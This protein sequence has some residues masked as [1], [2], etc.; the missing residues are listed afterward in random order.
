[1]V[2]GELIRLRPVAPSDADAFWRWHNDPEVMRFLVGGQDESLAQIRK[3]F[4][5]R[6]PNS[7]E[8]V[9]FGIETLAE[10]K[11]IG[12]TAL[13]DATPEQPRA[14]VDIYIGEKDH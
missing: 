14:E 12:V 2:T 10:G 8:R 13:R 3:R 5:D 1:M 6:P 7:H 4:E 11:L 9:T